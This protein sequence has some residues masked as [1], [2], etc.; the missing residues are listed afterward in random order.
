MYAFCANTLSTLPLPEYPNTSP[1]YVHAVGNFAIFI[2]AFV[3]SIVFVSRALS[4]NPMFTHL[5]LSSNNLVI[6]V[7]VNRSVVS[8]KYYAIVIKSMLLIVV[9]ECSCEPWKFVIN[10]YETVVLITLEDFLEEQLGS[11]LCGLSYFGKS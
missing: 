8:M 3:V 5:Y 11:F 10:V 9:F 1:I 6:I 2:C 7:S 4:S